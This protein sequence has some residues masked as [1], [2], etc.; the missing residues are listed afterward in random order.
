MAK[1][2]WLWQ[3]HNKLGPEKGWIIAT[4]LRSMKNFYKIF[5][6]NY[7]VEAKMI[8]GVIKVFYDGVESNESKI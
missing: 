7:K 8:K 1:I 6:K 3:S 4:L 2:R 5:N